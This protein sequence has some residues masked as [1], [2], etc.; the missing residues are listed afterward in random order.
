MALTF[1]PVA[2]RTPIHRPLPMADGNAAG[3]PKFQRLGVSSESTES[4]DFGD[5]LPIETEPI[6]QAALEVITHFL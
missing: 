2:L 5:L 3:V 1:D 4:H 6:D